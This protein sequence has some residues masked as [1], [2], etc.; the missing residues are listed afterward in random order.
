MYRP[1]MSGDVYAKI[2]CRTLPQMA[3]VRCEA[4]SADIVVSLGKGAKESIDKI[5]AFAENING[6]LAASRGLVDTGKAPYE[7][8]VGL[9]GKK[10]SPKVYVA[11][12]ISGAAHHT[13]GCEGAKYVIAVNHDK[14][15]RIFDCA[16]YG[17][18]ADIVEIF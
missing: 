1:A 5:K 17:V 11:I 8:Q 10:V 4:K 15:A 7:H 2:E 13:V 3:T 18:V 14:D 16:D 12:G 6:E 9:T